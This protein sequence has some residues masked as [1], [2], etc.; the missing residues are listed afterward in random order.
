MASAQMSDEAALKA[1]GRDWQSWRQHLDAMGA[2]SMPHKD[3]AA[4]LSAEGVPGWWSQ[5]VT[6]E[7]ERMIGRRAV[8]QRCDGDYS[9]NASRTVDGDM[10]SALQRWLAVVDGMAEFGGVACESEPR[11]TQ[12]AAWRYWKVDLEDG[13]RVSVNFNNKPGGKALAAVNHDRVADADAV[14]RWKAVWKPL[15]AAI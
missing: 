15:L 13:S 1:T 6:V 3:I 10:D 5:M 4:R 14:L 12:S 11:V 7:Y 8:G 9:A 2:A